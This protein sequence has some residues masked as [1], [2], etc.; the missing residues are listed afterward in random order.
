VITVGVDAECVR[1]LTKETRKHTRHEV[2]FFQRVIKIVSLITKIWE[3]L[4]GWT[5][6]EPYQFFFDD[7]EACSMKVYKFLCMLKLADSDARNRIGCIA[8]GKR[9]IWPPLQGADL[10]CCATARESR[11]GK[12]AWSEDGIFR[13][14]LESSDPAYGKSYYSEMWDEEELMKNEKAIRGGALTF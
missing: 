14:I 3:Q 4:L 1:R 10:L 5:E 12:N 8:F 9:N 7:A 6:P 2:F 11:Y 13:E